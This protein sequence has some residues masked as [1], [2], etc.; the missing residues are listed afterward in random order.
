[1]M[2]NK[3]VT[4]SPLLLLLLLLPLLLLLATQEAQ[5]ITTRIDASAEQ[6]F[7]EEIERGEKVLGSF[8]VASGG[9]LDIDVRVYGPDNNI[10]FE[11]ERQTDGSFNFVAN[12]QGVHRLC[13][14]NTM[15]TVTSKEVS[16]NLYV[17]T[18]LSSHGV[19]KT[20]HLSPLETSVL[21]LSEGLKAVENEQNY[22]TVRNRACKLTN[23]STHGRVWFWSSLNTVAA[24]AMGLY[25]VYFL[26]KLVEKK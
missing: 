6:C 25:Q 13:F 20:E 19:A 5:A 22:L 23:E 8:N 2:I 26:R 12:E 3:S 24:V 4:L 11:M 17:G 1:M 7:F 10:V 14:G 16:F 15:S 9:F 21:M 18:S